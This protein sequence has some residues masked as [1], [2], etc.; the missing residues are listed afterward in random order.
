MV[1]L[2]GEMGKMDRG[3]REISSV[4]TVKFEVQ[5]GHLRAAAAELTVGCKSLE[6][7][8]VDRRRD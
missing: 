2:L 6:H 4:F 3:K 7:R 1:V 8:R 5:I